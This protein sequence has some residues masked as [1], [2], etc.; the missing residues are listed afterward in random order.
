MSWNVTDTN[1]QRAHRQNTLK[2][3]LN[4]ATQ[5]KF[6]PPPEAL[7]RVREVTHKLIVLLQNPEN[8][9]KVDR[10]APGGSYGKRTDTCL[11]VDLDIVVFI[12]T[13]AKT[14]RQGG[15]DDLDDM[16]LRNDVFDEWRS[17]LQAQL[18]FKPEDF[19]G[20]VALSFQMDGIDI[21]LV[22]APSFDQDP[23]ENATK[24][25][26]KMTSFTD[27]TGSA[28]SA[29]LT[30]VAI[31][32][33][34]QQP[35]HTNDLCRLTKFWQNGVQYAER[36]DGRSFLFE[37]LSIYTVREMPNGGKNIVEAFCSFLENVIKFQK[38]TVAFP[39]VY[40]KYIGEV[41]VRGPGLFLPF[42][43]FESLTKDLGSSFYGCFA[44]AARMTLDRITKYICG[45]QSLVLMDLL[46][47]WKEEIQS[48]YRFATFN[49]IM[50]WDKSLK[51]RFDTLLPILR[52]NNPALSSRKFKSFFKQC[53]A[54]L[55][56][57]ELDFDAN[58]S[59]NLNGYL[60]EVFDALNIIRND[61]VAVH[62]KM[63]LTFILPCRHPD[64]QGG[65]LISFQVTP[66]NNGCS[67][68]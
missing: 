9:F 54:I 8:K 45:A 51:S 3:R 7:R 31:Q 61:N 26:N 48:F 59:T 22:P 13:K 55:V 20:V 12:S 67:I 18:G 24:V 53:A 60:E 33:V 47:P 62:D 14:K 4:G 37:C 65:F 42:N 44:R 46:M 19:S 58:I 57:K 29:A 64:V 6:I 49:I 17:L 35:P 41:D 36:V 43:P 32:F 28:Y 21:D 11:K 66:S 27:K 68:I 5:Q 63:D 25:Y 30:E 10:C 40:E 2:A 39:E 34:K 56:L 52:K 1:S 38:L 15:Y 16:Q 50:G 23:T